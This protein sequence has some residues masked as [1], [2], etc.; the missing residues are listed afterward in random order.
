MHFAKVDYVMKN[1]IFK[2]CHT[3]QSNNLMLQVMWIRRSEM[4]LF[5]AQ[6]HSW[7][8]AKEVH[9]E[10]RGILLLAG[11]IMHSLPIMPCIYHAED[12]FCSFVKDVS[13]V[14]EILFKKMFHRVK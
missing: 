13:G 9:P 6:L 4:R 7:A 12:R 3:E 14:Q 5:L 1:N 8:E 10:I 11:D 2:Y